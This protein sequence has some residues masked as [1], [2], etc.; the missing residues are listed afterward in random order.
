MS[1]QATHPVRPSVSARTFWC[2]CA[3]VRHVD[4]VPILA[5][6]TGKEAR[7]ELGG[8]DDRAGGH[9]EV[10]IVGVV[11]PAEGEELAATTETGTSAGGQPLDAGAD[12]RPDIRLDSDQNAGS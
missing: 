12:D 11:G 3:H 4:A 7:D 8:P 5:Q 9:S 6:L 10:I 2:D 1:D